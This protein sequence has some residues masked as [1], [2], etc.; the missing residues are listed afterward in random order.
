MTATVV[1]HVMLSTI[2]VKNVTEIMG[3]KMENL[4]C[5]NC[6]KS[7]TTLFLHEFIGDEGA[8]YRGLDNWI[9]KWY[10]KTCYKKLVP[11]GWSTGY[12]YIL[13]PCLPYE[14]GHWKTKLPVS[15]RY[16]KK[17]VCIVAKCYWCEKAN[18]VVYWKQPRSKCCDICNK[19]EWVCFKCFWECGV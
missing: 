19:P 8:H 6:N 10:C 1:K 15:D 13:K 18:Q 9:K 4:Y 7:K 5:D 3:C 11:G 2:I 16:I 12:E 14:R 17:Q